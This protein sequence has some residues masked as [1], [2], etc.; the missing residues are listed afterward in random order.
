[1]E[2]EGNDPLIYYIEPATISQSYSLI[3]FA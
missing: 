1:M 3:M 2:N